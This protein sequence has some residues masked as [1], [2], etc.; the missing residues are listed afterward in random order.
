MAKWTR[1]L[2]PSILIL[3]IFVS[4]FFNPVYADNESQ[5]LV[6]QGRQLLFENG[7]MTVDGLLASR[8]L[9]AQAVDK[10]GTDQDANAFFGATHALAFLYEPG[11]TPEVTKQTASL[12]S[13]G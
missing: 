10:D 5:A 13:P 4:G 2:A 7:D 3:F 1:R 8:D 12:G 6:D 9:F 11:T